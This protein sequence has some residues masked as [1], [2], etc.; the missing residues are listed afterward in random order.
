MSDSG[1]EDT[2]GALYIVQTIMAAIGAVAN[3]SSGARATFSHLTRQQAAALSE[4]AASGEFLHMAGDPLALKAIMLAFCDFS[5]RSDIEVYGS[6][7]A[8]N[9]DDNDNA[10]NIGLEL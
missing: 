9:D 10:N 6:S 1:F 2:V 5:E 3:G 8:N 7:A 4:R